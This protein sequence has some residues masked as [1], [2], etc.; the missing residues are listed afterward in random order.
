MP[1]VFSL[2][3]LYKSTGSLLQNLSS[4]GNGL[5]VSERARIA[6]KKAAR[7]LLHVDAEGNRTYLSSLFAT[8]DG[9]DW[10]FEYSGSWFTIT[11]SGQDCY[12]VTRWDDV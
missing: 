11:A 2:E 9:Q 10:V 1:K 12:S 6:H 4:P 7:F 8:K 3:G 5:I